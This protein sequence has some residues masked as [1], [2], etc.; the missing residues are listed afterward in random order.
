VRHGRLFGFDILRVVAIMSVFV[1]HGT[2]SYFPQYYVAVTTFA[3]DGVA[4]FF[5]LSGY[6]ITHSFLFGQFRAV[7]VA[8]SAVAAGNQNGSPSPT[9]IDF[10]QFWC[11]RAIRTIPPYLI[12]I[13]IFNLAVVG[14]G[15]QDISVGSWRSYLFLQNI[16]WPLIDGYPESWSLSVE[17]WFYL[18]LA[19]L[20]A[21]CAYALSSKKNDALINLALAALCLTVASITYRSV[22]VLGFSQVV[23]ASAWEWTN[24]VHKAAL[25]RLDAPALGVL[26]AVISVCYPRLWRSPYFSFPCLLGA[27]VLMLLSRKLGGASFDWS[28]QTEERS[29]KVKEGASFFLIIHPFVV[30]LSFVLLFPFFSTIRSNAGGIITRLVSRLAAS[31]FSIYL[32]HYSITMFVLVP[33]I[34]H[35]AAI[36]VQYYW[37]LYVLIGLGGAQIF[38]ILVE[39]PF[40]MMKGFVDAGFSG[41][42]FPAGDALADR[43][44]RAGTSTRR[45]GASTEFAHG[46][47]IF[48]ILLLV[49]IP[50]AYFI[51]QHAQEREKGW[52]AAAYIAAYEKSPIKSGGACNFDSVKKSRDYLTIVGWGILSTDG[53]LADAVM[54]EIDDGK[55]RKRAP[56]QIVRRS[57]VADYF[58]HETLKNSGFSTE[59]RRS[60]PVTLKVL[61]AKGGMLYECGN[62][63][64]AS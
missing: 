47:L 26:A 22:V 33:A 60:G 19:I 23:M 17:E 14:I 10:A 39:R 48:A 50:S 57:D 6:L 43:S 8:G 28:G 59:I 55:T 20:S 27:I 42:R 13:S 30:A 9:L 1:A 46:R 25:G 54:L 61:Q 58:K 31:A 64:S 51:V 41:W 36:P 35:R 24:Y 7:S 53:V 44:Q 5:G 37:V 34:A 63:Y 11:K 38:Y 15:V 29:I 12:A 3:L 32:W 21:A 52:Q 40:V 49:L 18:S 62:S 2:A 4:L 56:V 16:A 45:R